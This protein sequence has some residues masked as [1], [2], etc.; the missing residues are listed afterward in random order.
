MDAKIAAMERCCQKTIRAVIRLVCYMW[1]LVVLAVIT[2]CMSPRRENK[3]ENY[4]N[5]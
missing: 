5:K 1:M 3:E 4:E 2:G